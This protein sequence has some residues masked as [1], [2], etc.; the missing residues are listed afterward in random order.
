MKVYLLS[1]GQGLWE[2]L[3]LVALVLSLLDLTGVLHLAN[4]RV[5]LL[6]W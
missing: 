4:L 6:G 1:Y 5:A 3:V 2:G